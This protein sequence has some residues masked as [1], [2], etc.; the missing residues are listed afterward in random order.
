MRFGFE[1][2]LGNR[3]MTGKEF[4]S[5]QIA[6]FWEK[7]PVGSNFV[8][9]SDWKDFFIRYDRF[10]YTHEPHILEE[11]GKIDFKGKRV[12]EI[13]MGQGAEAQKIIEA[14]AIYNGI[15]LTQES[16]ARV[17]LRCELFSLPY[18]SLQ[19]MNAERLDF[20]DESFD[21]VFSHGVLH[22]SPRIRIIIRE[23]HRVLRE[24][25][26]VVIMLYHRNSINYQISIRCLRRL[27]I[28]LLFFPGMSK[29]VAK[30]THENIERLER[31][32]YYLR[33][34]GLA[35]LKME[36]FIHKATD[37]P[38]NVFSSVFSQSEAAELFSEFKN[39]SFSKHFLN[40]R[41]LP[42]LRSLLSANMKK[43]I[44]SRYGWHLWIKGIKPCF[45]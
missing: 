28:V 21:I 17:K 6:E 29:L 23:I 18:E 9:A 5:E 11:I 27:G 41:H 25:G 15:D 7:H 26:L 37:G 13:G 20:P 43:K 33:Q 1:P 10:K 35:Y 31:H 12:L 2:F 30:L 44:A 39:L 45:R 32:L 16:V 14:G 42:I 22:H 24:G 19:V 4:T 3:P 34:D 40:E 38:D 8:S 36:N